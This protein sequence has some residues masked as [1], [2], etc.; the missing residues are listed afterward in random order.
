MHRTLAIIGILFFA[1]VSSHMC[2]F[3]PHQR[4]T[5]DGTNKKGASDC[6][7]VSPGPCGGRAVESPVLIA[8]AGTNFTVVFQKNLDHWYSDEPGNFTVSLAT[9]VGGDFDELATVADS[10][11]P[12][13][14][15]FLAEVALPLTAVKHGVLQVVYYPNNPAAPDT[16]YQCADFSIMPM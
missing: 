5:M 14:S 12:S 7:L 6:A 3:N 16:F 13:L 10:A 4:G 15:F 2:L 1:S 9:S 8:K 11:A